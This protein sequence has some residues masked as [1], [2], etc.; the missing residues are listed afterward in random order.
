MFQVRAAR[1]VDRHQAGALLLAVTAGQD[2]SHRGETGR[3]LV[4]GLEQGSGEFGGTVIIEQAEQLSRK[5]R[6]RF[7]ALEG[8]LKERLAFGNQGG[9]AAGAAARA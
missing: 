9:Q 1:E 8:G 4:E 6:G 7:A 5:A 3:L 2:E